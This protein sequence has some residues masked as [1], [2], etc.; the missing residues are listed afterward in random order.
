M[1][2]KKNIKYDHLNKFDKNKKIQSYMF[3]VGTKN[4]NYNFCFSAVTLL[5][6]SGLN[7]SH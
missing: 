6:I 2:I 3:K 4:E 7:F 5:T 1:Q